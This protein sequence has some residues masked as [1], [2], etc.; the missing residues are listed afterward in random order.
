M[1][2]CMA[3]VLLA[4]DSFPLPWLMVPIVHVTIFSIYSNMMH[5]VKPIAAMK[6]HGFAPY[7]LRV[8][9]E[10]LCFPSTSLP[11]HNTPFS[12]LVRLL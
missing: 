2:L 8:L 11:H 7:T 4:R 12:K 1:D 3:C 6:H 9:L 5:P 10:I